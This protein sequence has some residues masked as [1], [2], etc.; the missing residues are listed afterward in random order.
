MEILFRIY[1]VEE[2]PLS[3]YVCTAT[4]AHENCWSADLH[5]NSNILCAEFLIFQAFL[6]EKLLSKSINYYF[7]CATFLHN[8][9]PPSRF[10]IK[11]EWRDRN[12]KVIPDQKKA[13]W[14]RIQNKYINHNTI[15]LR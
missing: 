11:T 6:L 4:C 10:I 7:C 13:D 12:K 2:V 1:C 14:N 3:V 15:N 5:L 8:S 9:C